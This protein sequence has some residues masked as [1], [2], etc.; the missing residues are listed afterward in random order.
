MA[1]PS[2]RIVNTEQLDKADWRNQFVEVA[3]S[4]DD[5]ASGETSLVLSTV[6]FLPNGSTFT[7]I[8]LYPV[9]LA[10]SFAYNEGLVGQMVPE[11]GSARKINTA[12]TA[13]G[14]GSISKLIVHGSS[15]AASIYR[16]TLAFV[17]STTTLSALSSKLI[18]VGSSASSSWI[19]GLLTQSVDLFSADLT[20]YVDTVVAQGGL[21]GLLYKV[22]F[23]LI[24]VRRDPRQRCVAINF[25]EQCAMRGSQAGLN[26][27]Q[28][29]LVDQISFEFERV[30]PLL[31]VGPFSLSSD[32]A[33][34]M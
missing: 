9:G 30:R 15:L 12:G 27:G 29:Q 21:N 17:N 26:A 19:N 1:Q 34:G 13:M 25:L 32:T 22:P 7:D 10:Q 3:T 14:S 23:G 8:P 24:E 18:G 31:G 2:N 16:P 4:A 33:I 28:F 11:I 5:F 6:P 20:E